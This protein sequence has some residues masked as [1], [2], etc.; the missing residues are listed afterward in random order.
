MSWNDSSEVVGTSVADGVL[1]RVRFK[2]GTK[3][4]GAVDGNDK[5]QALWVFS[6]DA[7]GIYGIEHLTIAHA[8]RTAPVGTIVLASEAHNARLNNRDGLLL[9]VIR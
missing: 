9:R 4:R 8:G 3:C 6:A 5:P 1:A 2:E 7:C